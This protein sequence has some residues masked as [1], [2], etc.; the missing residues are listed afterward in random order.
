[1]GFCP[2]MMTQIFAENISSSNLLNLR[3]SA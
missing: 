1:M 2:Q 3:S